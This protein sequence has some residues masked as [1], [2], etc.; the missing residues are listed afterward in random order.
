[1]S[2]PFQCLSIGAPVIAKMEDIFYGD[3]DG[4]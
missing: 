3:G 4:D 1:L 2:K